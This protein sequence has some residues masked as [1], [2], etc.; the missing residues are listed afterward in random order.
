ML[1]IRLEQLE[2]L[3]RKVTNTH[4]RSTAKSA[5]TRDA[6]PRPRTSCAMIGQRFL[7]KAIQ[8]TGTNVRLKLAVP[9]AGIEFSI[10][11]PELG[12]LFVGKR[13]DFALEVFEL[14]HA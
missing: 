6:S 4:R 10:P 11:P 14:G 1:G 2:V 9:D 13:C 3:I 12:E 5:V 7:G 8:G